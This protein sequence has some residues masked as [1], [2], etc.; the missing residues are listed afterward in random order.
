M[1]YKVG[2][3]KGKTH[4]KYG[5][6][7]TEE[8]TYWAFPKDGPCYR[9]CRQCKSEYSTARWRRLGPDERSERWPS[10]TKARYYQ[11]KH[12]YGITEAE[13]HELLISQDGLCRICETEGATHIDHDH[14]TG[15]VRGILCGH[16]NRGMGFFRDDALVL[17]AAIDYLKGER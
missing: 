6:E 16:C 17:A 7:Y 2:K 12:K 15:E 1:A 10:L 11:R 13:Y 5:H 4:C 3:G 14:T 8:N 9:Q